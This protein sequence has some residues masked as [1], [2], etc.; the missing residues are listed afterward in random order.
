VE[1]VRR[2]LK[3]S[4]SRGNPPVPPVTGKWPKPLLPQ[5]A[6][7]KSWSACARGASTWSISKNDDGDFKIIGYKV[8]PK[9]YWAEDRD[10]DIEFPAG[11]SIDDVIDRIIVILKRAA[12]G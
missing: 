7:V 2:A 5:Y 9:G 12:Q 6:G 3:E 4:I 10:Q 1:G 8:D 11:T